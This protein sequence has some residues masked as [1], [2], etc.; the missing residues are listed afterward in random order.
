[1]NVILMSN[2]LIQNDQ[3]YADDISR[4][5]VDN[6]IIFIQV[7]LKYVPKGTIDNK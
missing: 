3:H 2:G 7:A 6:K 1:M 5:I 4:S